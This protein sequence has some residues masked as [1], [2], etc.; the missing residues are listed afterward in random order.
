[1]AVIRSFHEMP[2]SRVFPR[3]ELAYH[4]PVGQA[5]TVRIGFR[6]PISVPLRPDGW[7]EVPV[8]ASFGPVV[9]VEARDETRPLRRSKDPI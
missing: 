5:V 7:L 3:S 1:M 9:L 8:Q 2:T 6:K 4:T